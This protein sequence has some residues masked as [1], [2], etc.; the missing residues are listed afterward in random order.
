MDADESRGILSTTQA[1]AKW[2]TWLDDLFLTGDPT[3]PVGGYIACSL[4]SVNA[5][6]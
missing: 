2:T 3:G 5:G 6:N 4:T 1:L